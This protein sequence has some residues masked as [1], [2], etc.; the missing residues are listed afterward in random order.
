MPTDENGPKFAVEISTVEEFLRLLKQREEGEA[1]SGVR[2][3]TLR[4][5]V[6]I[7]RMLD[8]P[9]SRFGHPKNT[10]HVVAAFAHES[11][12]VCCRRTTS[13]PPAPQAAY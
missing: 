1:A 7:A 3:S 10:R 11:D 6:F 5:A 13:N 8:Q 9:D 12:V 2:R 4:K